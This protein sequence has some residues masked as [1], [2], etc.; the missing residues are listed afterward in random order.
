MKDPITIKQCTFS[1]Y[2]LQEKDGY[3]FN[4]FKFEIE[5]NL[6]HQEIDYAFTIKAT[7]EGETDNRP[8]TQLSQYFE[9]VSAENDILN[10]EY[11]SLELYHISE[12]IYEVTGWINEKKHTKIN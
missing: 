1:D 10:E 7:F 2:T 6:R 5:G 11:F 4:E 3:N 8:V 9:A 12:V